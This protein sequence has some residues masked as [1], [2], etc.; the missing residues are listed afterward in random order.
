MERTTKIYPHKTHE[1]NDELA[2][3]HFYR[4]HFIGL[5]RFCFSFLQVKEPAEEIVHDAFLNLWRMKENLAKIENQEVYLYVT[6]KNL[7][8]NYLRDNRKVHLISL[9]NL[10]P[11]PIHFS[12]DPERM[13]ISS[14][15]LQQIN[16]AIDQLPNR[17]KLIFKLIKEDGLKYR[18]V[19]EILGLSIKTVE[20]Q[21]SIALKKISH[22][23]SLKGC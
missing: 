12:A 20:A 16:Q 17:C 23:L 9:D 5:Y 6:V 3:K 4:Q 13:L 14:Q 10:P 2:F 8:L 18:Q 22:S 11:F 21:L 15:A 7:S 1:L 19:A